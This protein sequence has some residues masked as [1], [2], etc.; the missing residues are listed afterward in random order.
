LV[1]QPEAE[2]EEDEVCG[3]TLI[4]LFPEQRRTMSGFFVFCFFE[5]HKAFFHTF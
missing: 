5:N 2:A 1:L 3:S 4:N